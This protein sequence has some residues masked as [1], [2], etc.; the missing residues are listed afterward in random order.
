MLS[1]FSQNG[2]IQ[3]DLRTTNN[4]GKE[5][6]KIDENTGDVYIDP[7]A[8][9][10]GDKDVA[11]TIN[12]LISDAST[13]FMLL[14]NEYQGIATDSDGNVVGDFSELPDN[15]NHYVWK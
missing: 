4:S 13:V 11:E 15:H 9:M 6:F 8:F 14:S 5:T 1:V 7:N 3:E 12:G 10:L 2:L